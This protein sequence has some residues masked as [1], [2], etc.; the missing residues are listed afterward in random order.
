MIEDAPGYNRRH[1]RVSGPLAKSSRS[2][3]NRAHPLV[4]GKSILWII[5]LRREKGHGGNRGLILHP[6][7][8][9]S[10]AGIRTANAAHSARQYPIRQAAFPQKRHEL[11]RRKVLSEYR[12]RGHH[13]S[14]SAERLD[15]SQEARDLRGAIWAGFAKSR[16]WKVARWI[17]PR[18]K[19]D[20]VVG[21]I[22][23][24]GTLLFF[25]GVFLQKH[26]PNKTMLTVFFATMGLFSL[27]YVVQQNWVL[28]L[29]IWE[30]SFGKIF[31]GV[32]ASLIATV[33]KV[34]ADQ[35][36]RLLT[37][38]N[39]SLFPSAQQAITVFNIISIT[40]AVIGA[41][42]YVIS[43]AQFFWSNLRVW[44]RMFS[45]FDIFSIR[46]M[47]G[48]PTRPRTPRF[49]LTR[50][51]AY[52]W[53]GVFMFELLLFP[54]DGITVFGLKRF[55]P[56]EELLLLSSFIRN[57]RFLAG[58]DL[59]CI[60]LPP[61]ALVFPFNTKDPIPNQVL[62]AQP[63]SAGPGKM[64]PSYTYHVVDCSPP[65]ATNGE[66]ATA[67]TQSRPPFSVLRQD[68]APEHP[69]RRMSPPCSTISE[70]STGTPAPRQYGQGLQRGAD[71]P[72]R[73]PIQQF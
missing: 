56:T 38:S 10:R 51:F 47:F 46:E 64:G 65:R 31:Y 39:P 73:P 50:L 55:D 4:D 49:S 42:L 30:H 6:R 41:I 12:A 37:Q 5:R 68:C 70:T 71:H 66:Q 48:L 26:L 34:G 45:I 27:W 22:I 53:A 59:V 1:A 21:T 35:E 69:R 23:F 20:A 40:L 36:I 44:G 16:Y 60:S 3:P 14:A 7:M 72:P 67:I 17:E 63:I 2:Y 8:V 58:S 15:R 9:G 28:L 18:I 62:M 54:D 32:M 13:R 29:R 57:D 52:M 25:G 33:S 24:W 19:P 43:M 61:H 11:P